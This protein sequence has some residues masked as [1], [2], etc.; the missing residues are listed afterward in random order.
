[1]AIQAAALEV[2]V[3]ANTAPAERGLRQFSS[4]LNQTARTMGITGAVMTGALTLPLVGLGKKALTSAADFEQSMNVLR[5][6]TSA[7]AAAMRDLQEQALRLGAETSFSAG[8][9][10]AAMLELG[11]AGMTTEEIMASIGGVLSLAAAGGVGLAE[12]ATVT[13]AALNTFGLEASEAERVANLLAAAANA[14]AADIGDLSQGLQ[15]GGFAFAA[16]GQS[17][18]DLVASLAILTNV[19]LT[20]SDAGTALK[21]AM[22]RL[23][24]PTQEASNLMA[25]LGINVFDAQGN[26]L[27]MAD[28]IAELNTGLQGMTQEQ[29]NA[30]LNTIFLS[31]GMKAMIPLLDSGVDGFNTMK[32]AVNQQGAA[33]DVA[34]ARM[35]GLAGAVEYLSG[36][37]D[38]FLI[39]SAQ[40]FL[41]SLAS[42]LRGVAD[43]ITWFGALPQP[44]QNAALAFA[45][46]LAAA[47]PVIGILGAVAGALSF[48]L[49]PLGVIT[50]A[51]AALSAAWAADFGGIQGKTAAAIDFLRPYF[52]ELLGWLGAAAKGDFAPLKEGLQGAL[53]HVQATI[54]QFD[55][56]EF[57]QKLEWPAFVK[58]VIWKDF[59][60]QLTWDNYVTKMGSWDQ[61][62][63]TLDWNSYVTTTID[64]AT[65][66]PAL[67][68]NTYVSALDWG[69][70]VYAIVWKEYVSPLTWSA[71]VTN[72]DDWG[73]WI[74]ALS[75]GAFIAPVLWSLYVFKLDWKTLITAFNEWTQ[76]VV[77]LTWS[78]FV[79]KIHWPTFITAIQWPTP[80]EI[81]DA[82]KDFF[83]GSTP[84]WEEGIGGPSHLRPQGANPRAPR[85][86]AWS[87]VWDMLG[88]WSFGGPGGGV[89]FSPFAVPVT[90]QI[91]DTNALLSEPALPLPVTPTIAADTIA[92]RDAM[93]AAILGGGK[94]YFEVP[95]RLVWEEGIGGSA[96]L[97][98]PLAAESKQMEAPRFEW[99]DLPKWEWPDLPVFRWP[100]LP[101]WTW[102]AIPRPSWIGE[103]QVPR[104]SWLGE[105]L[106]WSPT[107]V[108]RQQAQTV[109]GQIGNN[110]EGTDYWRGGLTWVGERG[111]ELVSLPR[112]SRIYSNEESEAML[113]GGVTIEQV[114]I[115]NDMDVE[116]M[117]YKVA[118][119]LGWKGRGR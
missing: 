1:M 18:D 64:W 112:G 43:A 71:V 78:S 37:V 38:S 45:A 56:A 95:A 48:L 21:N 13:A 24:A 82:I 97:A 102:P 85:F 84:Q 69:V 32:D 68:W 59:I 118:K 99:P 114:H 51:T 80:G 9:A 25:E 28:I 116:E 106:T 65:W 10:A 35:S 19:G 26:M 98:P 88:N 70:Y 12:A 36:S 53:N 40:P 91:A 77:P 86:D 47:G 111:P 90:P 96:A 14:S 93:M 23:M 17:I 109:P 113:A 101:N 3:G 27:P 8:E 54:E 16:A 62:V 7:P 44:I 31:D 72:L 29:R 4:S 89:G 92:Q 107:V 76:Y 52:Q 15:Q 5:Q 79:D 81:L 100:P 46:V 75:W 55:W 119:R 30:A 49:T 11:K 22:I 57:V 2:T 94:S 41:G 105:L 110:A 20:G 66:L 50:V 63:S 73:V 108:I 6:V 67:H 104:P 115:H 39:G 117:A 61:Y 42:I 34:S 87:M 103:L 60:S 83:R 33:A 74:V 58:S